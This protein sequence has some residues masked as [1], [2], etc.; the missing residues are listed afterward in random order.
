MHRDSEF[1]RSTTDQF[2]APAWE[3]SHVVQS[4]GRSQLLKPKGDALCSVLPHRLRSWRW[5]ESWRWSL[6]VKKRTFT[7]PPEG[8]R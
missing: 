6:W 7:D 4:L 8:S 2:M 3:L 5:S 1:S